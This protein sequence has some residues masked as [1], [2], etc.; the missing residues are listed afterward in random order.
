MNDQTKTNTPTEA[1]ITQEEVAY[2]LETESQNCSPFQK[3]ALRQL[4]QLL[5]AQKLKDERFED[6]CAFAAYI[7]RNTVFEGGEIDGAD[8]QEASQKMGITFIK[9]MTQELL[10]SGTFDNS[11]GLSEGDDC[12]YLESDVFKADQRHTAREAEKAIAG[13][14]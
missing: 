6:V 4:A 14:L 11:G 1:E 8:I 10:D 12:Y 5:V 3:R 13:K 9:P 7:I 2:F